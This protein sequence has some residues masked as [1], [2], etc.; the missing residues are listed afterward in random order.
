MGS[1]LFFEVLQQEGQVPSRSFKLL[2]SRQGWVKLMTRHTH[3]TMQ[4]EASINLQEMRL[5]RTQVA[6]AA[7]VASE[8]LP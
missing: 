5:P 1:S 4:V 8:L 2:L 6:G 3:V 7:L